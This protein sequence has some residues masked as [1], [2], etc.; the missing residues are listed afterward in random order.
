MGV[1][2]GGFMEESLRRECGGFTEE[3]LRRGCGGESHMP[4]LKLAH[5]E[6]HFLPIMAYFDM[7]MKPDL[8]ETALLFCRVT[9]EP[10]LA[11]TAALLVSDSTPRMHSEASKD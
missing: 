11:E 1:D 6:N 7:S 2:G 10:K 5:F 9:D 8:A 3:S 4:S